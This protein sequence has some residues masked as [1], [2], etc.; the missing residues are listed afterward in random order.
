MSKNIVVLSDGTG[1]DGGRNSD[2]NVYRLFKMLENRT[3]QQI[4]FYDRG[5][6][7]QSDSSPFFVPSQVPWLA[8]FLRQI[9]G[10]G[11]ARNVLDCYKFIFDNYSPGDHIFLFGFSRGAATV[12]SVSGFMDLFG[13]LPKSRPELIGRAF[14]LYKEP[15]PG[16]RKLTADE[17]CKHHHPMWTRIKF[18]GVWDTVFSVGGPYEWLSVPVNYISLW[19]HRFHNLLLSKSVEHARHAL[20]IDEKRYAFRPQLWNELD[21]LKDYQ[22]VSQVWFTGVHSDIGGG[23]DDDQGLADIPLIWMIKEA[24][25]FGLRLYSSHKVEIS[26]GAEAEKHDSF[27]GAWKYLGTKVRS[28]NLDDPPTVH[29]S[30]KI[31]DQEEPGDSPWILADTH[32]TEPWPDEHRL[33]PQRLVGTSGATAASVPTP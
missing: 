14:K 1:A 4:A 16:K 8:S 10:R 3:D 2:S 33:S 21:K 28:W 29:E 11:F 19:R 31:R 9:S 26:P 24:Q 22:T 5:V 6:G 12:R 17:F 20:A 7:A 32:S 13:V 27:E 15:D 30:V 23:Y 25:Q 18:L